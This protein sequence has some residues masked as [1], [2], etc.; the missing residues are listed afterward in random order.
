V[1]GR[2]H[3]DRKEKGGRLPAIKEGDRFRILVE[4]VKDYAIFMLDIAGRVETWNAGAELIKGYRSDEVIGKHIELFYAPE[5]READLPRRLLSQA[6]SFGRVEN[7][8]WRVRKDGRRFWADVVITALR[9]P[10]G[11]LLGFGKVTRDLTERRSADEERRRRDEQLLRS[12]ERFRL[13]VNAVEDYAIF[14]LDPDGRVATWNIGAERMKG[15]TASEI[16]GQHV[17]RFH[18]DENVR[19]GKP[20]EELATA[21]RQGNAREEGWRV[22]KDG[23]KF[24][25]NVVLTAI[26]GQSGELLGFA[27][28]TRDLT[29]RLRLED[30]RLH[31]GRAEEAVRLR[32]EFL[33]IASHEL[34]TPLTALQIELHSWQRWVG[35][36][37]SRA[38]KRFAR[39]IRNAERLTAL[40]ESLLDVSRI[41]TGRLVLKPQPLDLSETI[42]DLIEG[43]RGAAAK[44][45]CEI[46]VTT[47]GPIQGSWDRLRLEQVVMNLLSNALKYAAGTHVSVSL[48][49]DGGDAVIE[50]A[51]GG[52]GIP[53]EALARIFGRFERAAPVRHYGGL[54]LGLYV[55]REIV[56]AQN[57]TITARNLKGGG[58]C[59]T[60]RL[61]VDAGRAAQTRA[62]GV[63]V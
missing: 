37:D 43:L 58:A 57:G 21:A 45:G 53:E 36:D 30:E 44:A 42:L 33:S 51:D 50:I 39:A 25:A 28:V 13:L 23:T 55:S 9:D 5:D 14:M 46:S 19:A 10:S 20:E 35:T 60:V 62:T 2:G 52:P 16:I 41:A 27:K 32:D 26:R 15:F 11:E 8:G 1:S 4:S 7:E 54:G 63:A 3:G 56:E 34:K 48:A 22:R 6:A 59:F 17:S 18:L 40:I 12:E 24:W 38:V 47:P 49:T 61:P 29:D 31:R